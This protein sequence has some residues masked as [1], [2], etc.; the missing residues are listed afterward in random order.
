MNALTELKFNAEDT[1]D[2]VIITPLTSW[3]IIS[4]TGDDKKSYLQGQLT[5]DVVAL[6]SSHSTLGAHCDA[7]GKVWSI[8]DLFYL[9]EGY[10][11]FLHASG[12]ETSLSELKKYAVFSKVDISLA[13]EQVF[14]IVGSKADNFIQ[15]HANSSDDVCQCLGGTAVKIESNRW[16]FIINESAQA[17]F[18][19]VT[20]DLRWLSDSI[21]DYFDIK[22]ARPRV[23]KSM[24][25]EHIPQALNLQALDGISFQKGCY[26]GQETVARA[27]Y[28]GMNKRS[29]YIINSQPQSIEL[30]PNQPFLVERSVGENWRKAGELICYHQQKNGTVLGLIILPN[31]LEPDTQLR[32]TDYPELKFALAQLP[33]PLEEES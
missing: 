15:Q 8:F 23:T 4:V 25:N 5:C 31:D 32:S 22:S 17:K 30:T 1:I 33:Y 11:L 24:Q 2:D 26:T 29:L 21:W 14:G 20:K 3:G 12:I 10:G 7:K 9:N 18:I 27:K 19:D 13:T 28:R 6:E 16:L